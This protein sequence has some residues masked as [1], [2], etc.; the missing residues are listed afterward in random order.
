MGNGQG[1][2]VHDI[3]Y[4]FEHRCRTNCQ[5]NKSKSPKWL[6]DSIN[7]STDIIL[8]TKKP[9]EWENENKWKE[10]CIS[11]GTKPLVTLLTYLWHMMATESPNAPIKRQCVNLLCF[12]VVTEEERLDIGHT[13]GTMG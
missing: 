11:V 2:R 5:W 12:Q 3:S 1:T 7:L 13:N 9:R 4:E 10:K 6:H 8:G